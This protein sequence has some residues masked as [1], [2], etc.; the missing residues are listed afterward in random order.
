MDLEIL[1]RKI[2]IKIASCHEIWASWAKGIS[3]VLST[4][5][6]R[7]GDALVCL[8]LKWVGGGCIEGKTVPKL[9]QLRVDGECW[10]GWFNVMGSLGL[11]CLEMM[12]VHGLTKGCLGHFD[13]ICLDSVLVYFDLVVMLACIP[14][15]P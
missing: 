5:T 10:T 13:Q 8:C 4:T 3:F 15:N 6:G 2:K 12:Q 9:L 11:P 7:G 1:I 14:L